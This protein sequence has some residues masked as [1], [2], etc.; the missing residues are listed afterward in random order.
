MK[1]T[2]LIYGLE[3]GTIKPTAISIAET[4]CSV[5]L[6]NYMEVYPGAWGN[7]FP[8]R[9]HRLSPTIDRGLY[10]VITIFS[11]IAAVLSKRAS[12]EKDTSWVLPYS[13]F[14]PSPLAQHALCSMH[15]L[16]CKGVILSAYRNCNLQVKV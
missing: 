3:S 2:D 12:E 16:A 10:W 1:I 6:R 5:S 11:G 8:A 4:C 13:P 9:V 7:C 14:S 15:Y